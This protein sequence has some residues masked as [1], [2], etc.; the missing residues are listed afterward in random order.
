MSTPTLASPDTTQPM[1]NHEY[2]DEFENEYEHDQVQQ[3]FTKENGDND[4][5]SCS[6]SGDSSLDSSCSASSCSASSSSLSEDED[7]SSCCT[8]LL[9]QIGQELLVQWSVPQQNAKQQDQDQDQ[10]L[11]AAAARRK[12]ADHEDISM[13]AISVGLRAAAEK[14]KLQRVSS[15]CGGTSTC[16]SST[17]NED[18]YSVDHEDALEGPAQPVNKSSKQQPQQQQHVEIDLQ[19]IMKIR[20]TRSSSTKTLTSYVQDK[21]N[22]GTCGAT[23]SSCGRSIGTI[24]SNRWGLSESD[25]KR[26]VMDDNHPEAQLHKIITKEAKSQNK[27]NSSKATK[28]R[29]KKTLTV[30][31][32]SPSFWEHYFIPV[33]PDRIKAYTKQAT[34]AVRAQDISKLREI[35]DRDIEAG[36]GRHVMDACNAQGESVQHLAA[37]RH[38]VELLKFLVQ[39]AQVSLKVRDDCGKTTLHE[40]CWAPRD[41]INPQY[42][43]A[44]LFAVQQ[45]PELLFCRDEK[46][47]SP[48]Y[49]VPKD[50]WE[51]WAPFLKENKKFFRLQTERVRFQVA[52]QRL[53]DR[54]RAKLEDWEQ[55]L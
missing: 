55:E 32:L 1:L 6:A 5:S 33:T 43:E 37:R 49:Y 25:Y 17:A 12:S 42:F 47:Y 10:E 29:R 38:S 26:L 48:L 22:A 30:P 45:C 28:D 46:G 3:I 24:G 15:G 2:D 39:E 18:S 8:A 23:R 9:D 44:V 16:T 53:L 41:H 34:E 13:Q 52:K 36:V 31:E 21:P 54:I 14:A 50:A 35:L 51:L 27:E 20:I 7:E 40:L 4:E 11:P 19:E